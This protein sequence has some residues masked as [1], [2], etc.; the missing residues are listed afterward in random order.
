MSRICGRAFLLIIVLCLAVLLFLFMPLLSILEIC[1]IALAILL[2]IW[3]VSQVDDQIHLHRVRRHLRE[4]NLQRMR[5][6]LQPRN[7]RF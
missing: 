2:F 5:Q 3:T 1:L 4:V 7:G 6:Q